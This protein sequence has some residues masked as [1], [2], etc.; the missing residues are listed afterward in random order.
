[1]T[2]SRV[3]D[4]VKAIDACMTSKVQITAVLERRKVLSDGPCKAISRRLAR[5]CAS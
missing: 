4:N 5:P 1:M 2:G 3:T